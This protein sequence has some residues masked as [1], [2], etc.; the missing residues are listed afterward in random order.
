MTKHSAEVVAVFALEPCESQRLPERIRLRLCLLKRFRER[1]DTG[2]QDMRVFANGSTLAG[3]HTLTLF[4][5]LDRQGAH[6]VSVADQERWRLGVI[7]VATVAII[8]QGFADDI[9]HV[10]FV[11]PLNTICRGVSVHPLRVC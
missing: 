8:A 6:G 1:R 10:P 7:D 11:P 2:K 9:G 3:F 4:V 5:Y